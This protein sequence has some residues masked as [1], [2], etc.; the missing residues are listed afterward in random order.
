ME[1]VR[2]K[3]KKTNYFSLTVFLII[4]GLSLAEFINGAILVDWFKISMAFVELILYFVPLSVKVM[5]LLVL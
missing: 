4:F 3:L 5:F 1:K 2:A